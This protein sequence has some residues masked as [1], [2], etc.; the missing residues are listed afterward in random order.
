LEYAKK[1]FAKAFIEAES[2]GLSSLGSEDGIVWSFSEKFEKSMNTLVKKNSSIKLSTR[3]T[4]RRSLLAA[5]I[6]LIIM[7]ASLMSVS[8]T[9]NSAIRFVKKVFWNRNSINIE[10]NVKI[11]FETI[12]TEYTLSDLPEGYRI[13]SYDKDD[14]G[15]FVIWINENGDEIVFAQDTLAMHFDIDNEHDYHE[16]EINGYTAYYTGNEHGAFLIWT[17]G[18]YWFS[19]SGPKNAIDYV[20]SAPEKIVEKN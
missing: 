16:Y 8:A 12:E 5:I 9:R 3:R 18:N 1:L 13:K 2:E 6:T 19:A 20:K 7:F 15:V 4:V 14:F 10:K 17:D 11:P